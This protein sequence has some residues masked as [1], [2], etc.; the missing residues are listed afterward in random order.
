MACIN[1]ILVI[2]QTKT[3]TLDLWGEDGKIWEGFEIY[4]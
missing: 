1:I 2:Y 4:Y 3:Q